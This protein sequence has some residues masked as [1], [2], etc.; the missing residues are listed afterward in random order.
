MRHCS[1]HTAPPC[2]PNNLPLSSVLA[3]RARSWGVLPGP[4]SSS[5]P[6]LKEKGERTARERGVSGGGCKLLQPR[7]LGGLLVWLLSCSPPSSSQFLCGP[8]PFPLLPAPLLQV[9]WGSSKEPAGHSSPSRPSP[10]HVL[11]GGPGQASAGALRAAG[12]PPI[13][14][15]LPGGPTAGLTA[16][17][18]GSSKCLPAPVCFPHLS[19]FPSSQFPSWAGGS[20]GC[21]WWALWRCSVLGIAGTGPLQ[22]GQLWGS[23]ASPWTRPSSPPSKASCWK[24]SW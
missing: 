14:A 15:R 19:R 7:V 20:G 16:S 1:R 4:G 23:R 3:A 13:W 22:R 21:A 5:H 24:P 10:P 17:L 2:P 9:G 11:P 6:P 8:P 18:A 12:R